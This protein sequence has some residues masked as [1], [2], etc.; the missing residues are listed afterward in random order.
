MSVAFIPRVWLLPIQQFQVGSF[1]L[2]VHASLHTNNLFDIMQSQTLYP[3]SPTT[4][5]KQLAL[6]IG[7]QPHHP[8]YLSFNVSSILVITCWRDNQK[9]YCWYGSKP[10][11]YSTSQQH[12]LVGNPTGSSN[13][14]RSMHRN[15]KD[16]H[17]SLVGSITLGG[18]G[19]CSETMRTGRLCTRDQH[20]WYIVYWCFVQAVCKGLEV[21]LGICNTYYVTAK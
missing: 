10:P 18:W 21:N 16:V 20:A 11:N 13:L 2:I 4:S 17:M 14:K 7:N 3:T 1:I 19:L 6:I 9:T 5:H 12:H 15:S 8:C